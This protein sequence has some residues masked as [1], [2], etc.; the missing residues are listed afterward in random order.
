MNIPETAATDLP[1]VADVLL[2]T[3]AA[4]TPTPNLILTE[5]AAAGA[6]EGDETELVEQTPLFTSVA[7]TS[8]INLVIIPRHNT[9][10]QVYVDYELAFEGRMLTGN[11]YDYSANA[12]IEINTGNAGSL[13][14]YFNDQ[15]IGP[16]GLIGQV[17]ALV[18]TENGLVQPT[19]TATPT[20]TKTPQA[21]PS[22]TPT[23]T[24][25]NDEAN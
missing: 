6:G 3:S 7:N 23:Q 1:E 22:P 2:A 10:V 14:I 11:A 8:A 20:V 16:I 9:W 24:P 12:L 21:T 15:D 17:A 18:F 25:T 5:E 13:Q 19:P 4:E